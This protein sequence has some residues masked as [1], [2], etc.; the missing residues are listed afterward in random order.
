MVLAGISGLSVLLR[1]LLGRGDGFALVF[2]PRLR[3]IVCER[4]VG[5]WSAKESLNGQE[6]GAD[7]EGRRPVACTC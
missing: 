7:L 3:N 1:P 2:L 4:I 5:V 6:N